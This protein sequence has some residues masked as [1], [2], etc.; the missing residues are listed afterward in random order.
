[1]AFFLIFFISILFSKICFCISFTEDQYA[2]PL[3]PPPQPPYNQ[4]NTPPPQIKTTTGSTT[5]TTLY[6]TTTTIK[7]PTPY[8]P[9]PPPFLPP[10]PPPRPLQHYRT[11]PVNT[12]KCRPP[13]NPCIPIE[14]IYGIDNLPPSDSFQ[15]PSKQPIPS[16]NLINSQDNGGISFRRINNGILDEMILLIFIFIFFILN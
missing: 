12:Y 14:G 16:Q 3:W 13:P 2:V 4:Y 11:A 5:T 6:I 9:A 1:M 8:P 10:L 7:Q 15:L